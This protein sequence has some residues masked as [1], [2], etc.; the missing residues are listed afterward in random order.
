M[1]VTIRTEQTADL[2]QIYHVNE[3]AFRT[4]VEARLVDA[5]RQQGIELISLVADDDGKVVGHILFSPVQLVN[6]T[7]VTPSVALGPMAVL[8]T[9]QN[10]SIGSRLVRAGLAACRAAGHDLV[11]V[12]GHPNFYPRFGFKP[13]APF[14]IRSQFDV[15]DDV[16]MVAELQPNALTGK[17]GQVVY[18]SAF[19]TV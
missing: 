9:Y 14:G 4:P 7:A 2:E 10:Q 18:H 15:P 12:L 19:Q 6:E 8:P 16:F 13:T 11:F 1:N 17:K 5:L 3:A